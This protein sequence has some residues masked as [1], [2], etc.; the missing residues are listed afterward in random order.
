M[1][2]ETVDQSIEKK[3]TVRLPAL[4]PQDACV[5]DRLEKL[6][7]AGSLK[8]HIDRAIIEDAVR[9]GVLQPGQAAVGATTRNSG[10]A[11]AM[12]CADGAY[13]FIARIAET[14]SVER[15]KIKRTYRGIKNVLRER[16]APLKEQSAVIVHIDIVGST[17]FVR[18]DMILAHK[19]IQSLY[20]RV[21]HI[22]N[23][24]SG[25]VYEIRGDAAV[26][27]FEIADNAIIAALLLQKT[28]ELLNSTRLG[29]IEPRMRI[30]ICKGDVVIGNNTITGE[31]V[32]IA[33][34]L[35]Q[36]AN[37][38]QVLIDAN[39]ITQ[40]SN[41]GHYSIKACDSKLLK[42]FVRP[43][44]IF[45]ASGN[46][47]QI[48]RSVRENNALQELPRFA[49][50]WDHKYPHIRKSWRILCPNQMTTSDSTGKTSKLAPVIN[51]IESL[52]CF[53]RK[54]IKN[55]NYLPITARN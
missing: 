13:D 2:Y 27:G 8:R 1:T 18:H 32:I 15:R 41:N 40:L 9:R 19:R 54:S 51:A 30:G 42:G 37:P 12:P 5:D 3:P 36:L 39:V 45:S 26:L 35:E 34:R 16:T 7:R 43:T 49:E 20:S 4:D 10:T 24:Y 50:I 14:F 21:R 47:Q 22:C 44:R 38:S 28:N 11:M 6:T 23:I 33:Q 55:E 48:Y 17:E 53:I 29:L 31:A 52:F 25:Y 46:L